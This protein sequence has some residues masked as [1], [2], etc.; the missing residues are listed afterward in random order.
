MQVTKDDIYQF[1]KF[2]LP[3]SLGILSEKG[4]DQVNIIF[5]GHYTTDLQIGAVSIATVYMAL[6]QLFP[7]LGSFVVTQN[8]LC[9]LYASKNFE[10]YQ[11]V[12]NR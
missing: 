1:L 7:M 9:R 5:A 11:Q 10:L 4:I 6:V 3:I 8:N 12:F 2:I